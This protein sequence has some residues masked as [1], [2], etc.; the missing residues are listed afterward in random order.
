VASDGYRVVIEP[1][2]DGGYVAACSKLGAVSQGAT[3]AEARAN[4]DEAIEL[5]LEDMRARGETIPPIG[6]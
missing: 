3:I 4:I 1:G 5:V 2:E 6:G